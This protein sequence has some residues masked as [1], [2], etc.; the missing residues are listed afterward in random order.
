MSVPEEIYVLGKQLRLLQP[1]EGFR[2][3]IDAVLLAAACPAKEGESI[4]DLGCG[5]GTAGL[6]V[7]TRIPGVNLTGIDIQGNHIDLAI[8][9]AAANHLSDQ[10]TFNISDIR[11]YTSDRFNHVI[12]NPPYLESGAHLR[13]PSQ[14]KA[15]AKGLED[16]ALQ[17]WLNCGHRNLKSGGSLTIIH[18]ADHTD[19]IIHALGRRFGALQI[20]PLWP[21]AGQTAKRVII[22]AIKDRKSPATLH[23]GLTLHQNNGEYTKEA[24]NVLRN[25]EA[26]F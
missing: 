2:T 3:S 11:D 16:A 18:R 1:P 6:C 17:D 24:E 23:A 8:Q 26:L 13:S 21:K 14:E 25:A 22:R 15:T 5:I 12:C 10:C 20:I 19:K 9:N 4:L 7:L